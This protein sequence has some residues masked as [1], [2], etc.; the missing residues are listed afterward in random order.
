[1]LSWGANVVATISA[2]N[3]YGQS[4]ISVVG[5]GAVLYTYPSA[6]T[7]LTNM[8]TITSSTQVGLSWSNCVSNGGSSVIDYTISYD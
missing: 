8:V 4:V 2:T 1:M 5:S 3:I 7:N 6:P